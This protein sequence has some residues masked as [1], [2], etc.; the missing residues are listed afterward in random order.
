[1]LQYIG[2]EE[3]ENRLGY[4]LDRANDIWKCSLENTIGVD[5]IPAKPIKGKTDG[6]VILQIPDTFIFSDSILDILKDM[7]Q[8]KVMDANSL[9]PELTNIKVEIIVRHKKE[10]TEIIF[11][12][13]DVW[14]CKD[15]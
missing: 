13:C 15:V 4:I 1:M 7:M 3:R 14:V 6:Y 8:C 5:Y 11:K 10:L 12:V 9:Y 2:V